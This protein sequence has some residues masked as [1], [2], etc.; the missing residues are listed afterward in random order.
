MVARCIIVNVNAADLHR[1]ARTLREIA[2]AATTSPG[3]ESVSA[4][5]MAIV[6]A[7]SRNPASAIGD[8]AERTGLAQSLVSKTVARFRARGL[9]AVEQDP[10]D[11]RRTLVTVTPGVSVDAFMP[12]NSKA[13]DEGIRALFPDITTQRINRILLGLNVLAD[14]V[15]DEQAP[16]EP[17]AERAV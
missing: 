10:R 11:G 12:Q 4:G 8:I 15:L 14:E 17:M 9:F 1:L 5:T 3:T 7:V 13:I 2:L 16:S 6:E